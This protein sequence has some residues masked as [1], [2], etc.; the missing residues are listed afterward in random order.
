MSFC[1]AVR[2]KTLDSDNRNCKRKSKNISCTADSEDVPEEQYIRR[3]MVMNSN[4]PVGVKQV[5]HPTRNCWSMV[6]R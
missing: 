4:S 6:E 2:H 5:C 3:K 1:R